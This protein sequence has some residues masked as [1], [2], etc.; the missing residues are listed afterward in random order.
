MIGTENIKSKTLNVDKRTPY[1]SQNACMH[2][3]TS[4][5]FLRPLDLVNLREALKTRKNDISAR[6]SRQKNLERLELAESPFLA[7]I[8]SVVRNYPTRNLDLKIIIR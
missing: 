4:F 7:I 2:L 6:A 1:L 8:M 3:L 5:T